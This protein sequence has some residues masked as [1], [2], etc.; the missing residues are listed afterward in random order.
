MKATF[1]Y[2]RYMKATF[3][4]SQDSM[5]AFMNPEYMK[6]TFMDLTAGVQKLRG[7]QYCGA[8]RVGRRVEEWPG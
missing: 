6:A 4:P 3:G 8:R 5:V 7:A 2:S 1:M